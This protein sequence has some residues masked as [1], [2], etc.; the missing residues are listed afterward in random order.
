MD[1][2]KQILRAVT[3]AKTEQAHKNHG[4]VKDLADE[5][6]ANITGEG[7]DKYL[8]QFVVR[9]SEQMFK[10]RVALTNSINPAVANSLMKPFYKVSRNNS[11]ARAYDFKDEK[12]NKK[13]E[14]MLNDFNGD[15]IRRNIS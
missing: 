1:F 12:I 4:R 6:L 5:Y 3:L 13:V 8:K 14:V 11:V 7:I 15:K 10:Q 2:T 9:E